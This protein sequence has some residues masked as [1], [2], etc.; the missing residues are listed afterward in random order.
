MTLSLPFLR[1]SLLLAAFSVL[2]LCACAAFVQGPRAWSDWLFW[3]AGAV[4]LLLSFWE[5]K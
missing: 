5:I 4:V 2:I 1:R 3:R